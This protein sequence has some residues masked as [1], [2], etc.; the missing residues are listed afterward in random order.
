MATVHERIKNRRKQLGLSVDTVAE[1]LGISRATVYRYEAAE[2]E[3]IP[4]D[5]L[6]AFAKILQTS[7]RYLIG[8]T[9]DIHGADHQIQIFYD[10]RPLRDSMNTEGA[11]TYYD[12]QT[13]QTAQAIFDDKN[14]R[15]LFDAAQDCR[16]EDL[17][18]AA[19]LL[20][21]LKGTNPDG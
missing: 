19:D 15:A 18:M 4:F 17:K 21:R 13:M 11:V 3:K 10:S 5:T 9:D 14:L 7:V 6:Q 20:S 1:A 2:I 16:P 8:Q 12:E